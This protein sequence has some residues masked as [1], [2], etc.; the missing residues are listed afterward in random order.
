MHD[1]RPLP[2]VLSDGPFSRKAA[3]EAGL[4]D[5][6]LRARDLTAP[7]YGVRMTG[8]VEPTVE[9][10]AAAYATRMRQG[11]AFSHGTAALLMGLPLPTRFGALPLHVSC[12]APQ[13]AARGRDIRGHTVGPNLWAM[14]HVFIHL[15]FD[16]PIPVFVTAARLTWL[17]LASELGVPDLVA[18]G[19]AM[20]T[21][22]VALGEL[23]DIVDRSPGGRGVA[24]ARAA[25]PMLR[26]G[27]MSRP[28][29]L[30]RLQIRAAGL[31]EPQVNVLVVDRADRPVFRLD[32]S[33][34]EY[35]VLVE[36]E[37]DGH[38]VSRTKF[39]SDIDRMEAF[40]D[41]GWAGI[42]ATGDDVFEHPDRFLSRLFRRLTDRGMPPR[43]LRRVAPASR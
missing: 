37:G 9:S 40:A 22:G 13:R 27:A 30:L 4:T 15:P 21:A 34:P 2:E 12:E 38:R 29:S 25:L 10:L 7:F 42:R 36:Y 16:A 18:L 32:L 3:V 1:P 20:L 24:R 17:S 28:E 5:R 33:W 6:R 31:P 11:C 14:S 23:A 19:D 35:R 39:R 26:P 43:A 41:A 8:S